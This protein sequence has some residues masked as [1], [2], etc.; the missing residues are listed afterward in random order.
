MLDVIFELWYEI[1]GSDVFLLFFTSF[2]IFGFFFTF[3]DFWRQ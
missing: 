1:I 3:I 2:I